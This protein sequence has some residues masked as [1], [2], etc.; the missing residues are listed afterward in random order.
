MSLTPLGN[1]QTNLQW[2][3]AINNA[4]TVLETVSGITY[5]LSAQNP[6]QNT[7]LIQEL[8]GKA[9]KGLPLSGRVASL[10][11]SAT[12][13]DSLIAELSGK[14]GK[15]T[16][17]S[18]Q[19]VTTNTSVAQKALSAN[20]VLTSGVDVDLTNSGKFVISG[21][22]SV[23]SITLDGTDDQD[24]NDY[25]PSAVSFMVLSGL[26]QTAPG[27]R[28]ANFQDNVGQ[29]CLIG[30][31]SLNTNFN[32]NGKIGIIDIAGVRGS[33]ASDGV[34]GSYSVA[35][36]SQNSIA[37]AQITSLGVGNTQTSDVASKGAMLGN[38]NQLRD[39]S[40]S[41]LIGSDN[42][43]EGTGLN[44]NTTLVGVANSGHMAFGENNRIESAIASKAMAIGQTNTGSVGSF[45]SDGTFGI[46]ISNVI[47]TNVNSNL[48]FG[49]YNN[50]TGANSRGL[51]LGYKNRLVDG[52]GVIAIGH[53]NNSIMA[54]GSGV[55]IGHGNTTSGNSDAILI[56]SQN[57]EISATAA[58]G[59]SNVGGQ[60]VIIGKGNKGQLASVSIGLTNSVSG[61]RG[62]GIGESN[63]QQSDNNNS[64]SIA[65]GYQ[66]SAKGE[67]IAIG[68]QNSGTGAFGSVIMGKENIES[69]QRAAGQPN[70]ILGYINKVKGTNSRAGGTAIAIGESNR[71]LYSLGGTN[72]LGRQNTLSGKFSTA[73]GRLNKDLQY[74]QTSQVYIGN[75]NRSY[76]SGSV[77]I[78][79]SNTLSGQES[80]IIGH[81]N[82]VSGTADA[83]AGITLGSDNTVSGSLYSVTIG[84]KNIVPNGSTSI[85]IG[86][87]NENRDGAAVTHRTNIGFRNITT[88]QGASNGSVALGYQNSGSHALLLGSEN[89]ENSTVHLGVGQTILAGNENTVG[90]LFGINGAIGYQ[91]TNAGGTVEYVI[92][93]QNKIN[94]AE[95]NNLI[96]GQANISNDGAYNTL[97]GTANHIK[98]AVNTNGNVLLGRSNNTRG[99]TGM[100]KIGYLNTDYN[101][102]QSDRLINNGQTVAIGNRNRTQGLNI[103]IGNSNSVSAQSSLAIGSESSAIDGDNCFVIGNQSYLKSRGS[104]ALGHKLSGGTTRTDAQFST[105]IG[106]SSRA[107]GSSNVNVGI[108]NLTNGNDSIAI[109]HLTSSEQL[110]SI[111]MGMEAGADSQD[112][113]GIGYQVSANS[114]RGVTIGATAKDVGKGVSRTGGNTL[115]GAGTRVV[116][117]GNPRNLGQRNVLIGAGRGFGITPVI[118]GQE[119]VVVGTGITNGGAGTLIQRSKSVV[120]GTANVLIGGGTV[121]GHGHTAVGLNNQTMA[122]SDKG[123]MLGYANEI[124]GTGGYQIAIGGVSHVR[125]NYG[126][127]IGLVARSKADSAMAIG[128]ATSAEGNQ[129]LA[130]GYVAKSTGTYS[131][132]VG[133]DTLA[134]GNQ[135]VAVGYDAQA[136]GAENIAIGAETVVSGS[137]NMAI[138]HEASVEGHTGSLGGLTSKNR[139]GMAIGYNAMVS[140][141]SHG[142]AIGTNV[143]T[144]TSG[145]SEF[146]QFVG[147][148][149]PQ[150]FFRKAGIR[151]HKPINDSTGSTDQATSAVNQMGGMFFTVPILS[152]A[153]LDGDTPS[154]TGECALGK[155]PRE[156]AGFRRK[157]RN[158][159]LDINIDGTMYGID[160][161]TAKVNVV[162]KTY[163]TSATGS[164]DGA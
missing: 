2:R 14:A 81:R 98:A 123:V 67:S 69:S 103:T 87:Q 24:I 140:G 82:D 134:D 113:I 78:G 122:S 138:G 55:I 137:S 60:N 99:G 43:A 96:F 45:T 139:F 30:G 21:H 147:Q 31:M 40:E 114:Y 135:T 144:T 159:I 112:A 149:F 53:S 162:A 39:S 23:K 3:N 29:N 70:V 66:N 26:T 121:S 90:S 16:P 120:S 1:N 38:S 163:G 155:I 25:K 19:I 83:K 141:A 146:G 73:I 136:K 50:N 94:H 79:D 57:Y 80:I 119:N 97:L 111:A 65:L 58:L 11:I 47:G 106:H 161:G 158:M 77:I 32:Y 110:H 160:L 117:I 15:G 115:V 101:N 64:G 63:I 126:M 5:E 41:Y 4:F 56:G 93:S 68:F 22:T 127:A 148:G 100:V 12:S 72:I 132:A 34:S 49:A 54:A 89:R 152:A 18:A 76:L 108:S 151:V 35:I 9:G 13:D 133:P 61:L 107:L 20:T 75:S 6:D 42:I 157:G 88:P 48:T 105:I 92:G 44:Q 91:N 102:A 51:I 71:S 74:G 150:K 84:N 46:G 164:S 143:Q 37:G 10:T 131:V 124:Q 142:V 130:I 62:I 59:S 128:R 27:L 85:N 109:G 95:G 154:L 129:S 145:T 52:E 104:V 33:N 17:L 118:S 36:G 28:F 153:P 116:P 125:N 7:V 86:V 156:M 8:S